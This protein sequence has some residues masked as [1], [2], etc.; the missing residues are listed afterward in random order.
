[1]RY[2]AGKAAAVF[3][4]NCIALPIVQARQFRYHWN[5]IRMTR[6]LVHGAREWVALPEGWAQV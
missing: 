3:W 1:V 6:Y 4:P 2:P 5:G